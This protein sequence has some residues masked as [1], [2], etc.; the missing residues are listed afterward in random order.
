MVGTTPG[1]HKVCVQTGQT[2]GYVFFTH[3]LT[4]YYQ[5]KKKKL[6]L[7]LTLPTLIFNAY[8]KVCIAILDNHCLSQTIVL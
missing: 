4:M 7:L 2:V 1:T 3:I 5:V 8:P 6:V